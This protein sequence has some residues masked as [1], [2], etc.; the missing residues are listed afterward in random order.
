MPLAGQ[1]DDSSDELEIFPPDCS[2]IV[3]YSDALKAASDLLQFTT[4]S[5]HEEIIEDIHRT[6]LGLEDFKLKQT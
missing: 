1:S 6:L 4:E 5:G 2:S 3:T